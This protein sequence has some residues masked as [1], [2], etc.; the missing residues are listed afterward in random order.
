MDLR[1]FYTTEISAPSQKKINTSPS[2]YWN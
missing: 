1:H 2:F